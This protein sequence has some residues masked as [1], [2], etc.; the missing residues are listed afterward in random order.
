LYNNKHE[1][2]KKL[3]KLKSFDSL[4]RNIEKE[5]TTKRRKLFP[6]KYCEK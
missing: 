6:K 5:N 3:F 4:N 2:N 1:N